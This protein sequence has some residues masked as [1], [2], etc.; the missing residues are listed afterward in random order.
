M[1]H[2]GYLTYVLY[3]HSLMS[4]SPPTHCNTASLELSLAYCRSRFFDEGDLFLKA[5]VTEHVKCATNI[6]ILSRTEDYVVV[7][8]KTTPLQSLSIP[9]FSVSAGV[10]QITRMLETCSN[11][12]SQ[13]DL[14]KFSTREGHRVQGPTLSNAYG[15]THS[16]PWS[17]SSIWTAYSQAELLS[18]NQEYPIP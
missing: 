17:I 18:H 9:V 6:L 3:P 11:V 12:S 16:L 13:M 8:L 7:V 4:C 2:S 10:L 14:R 15:Q 1:Q 5:E